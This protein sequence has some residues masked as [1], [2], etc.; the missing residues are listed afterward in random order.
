M[1]DEV[2]YYFNGYD[3]TEAWP[4]TP[5]NLVDGS[6]L[7]DAATSAPGDVELCNSNTCPGIYLGA[8]TK[9]ELRVFV[10]NISAANHITLRPVFPGGD[11][12]DH[13]V[14]ATPF[15][16]EW[17]AWQDITSDTNAPSPWTW[18][19]VQ[20]LDCDVVAPDAS[21]ANWTRVR[22]VEIRVT[23]FL[24]EAGLGGVTGVRGLIY[25][26]EEQKEG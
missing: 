19:D 7:T 3:V 11:G 8:I 10:G 6:I 15:V 16:A 18:S 5:A 17:L 26:L 25:L 4:T 23:Y 9:V 22:K 12:D 21:G 13:T 20:A 1:D 24:P 2:T 14:V